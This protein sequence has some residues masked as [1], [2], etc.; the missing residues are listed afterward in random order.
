MLKTN[1]PPP[2]GR[3][4]D[5][6]VLEPVRDYKA[7]HASTLLTFQATADAVEQIERFGP[8]EDTAHP[9]LEAGSLDSEP[10]QQRRQQDEGGI[11]GHRH[12][13]GVIG[14]CRIERFRLQYVP[15]EAQ[16]H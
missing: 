5:F 11:V 10:R 12:R 3:F 15:H 13:D 7:R 6:A 4:A 14:R 9:H 16:R 8:A 2:D 1:G